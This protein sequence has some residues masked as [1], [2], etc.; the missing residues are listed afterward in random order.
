MSSWNGC[1]ASKI[2]VAGVLFPSASFG[3]SHQSTASS[4]DTYSDMSRLTNPTNSCFHSSVG[5]GVNPDTYSLG[6]Q[7]YE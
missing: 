1:T 3:V 4:E 7:Q 5:T 2:T 6:V